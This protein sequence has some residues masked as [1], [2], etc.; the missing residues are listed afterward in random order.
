VARNTGAAIARGEYL[1]FLDDDDW[2]LPGALEQFW[3]LAQNNHAGWLYGGSRLIDV[4]NEQEVTLHLGQSGNCFAQAMAGEWIP[5]QASLIKTEAFFAVGGFNPFA[6]PGE[7]KDLCQRI[8]LHNNFVNTPDNV[9]V[10][11]REGERT[12]H[13]PLGVKHGRREREKTLNETGCFIRM[14]RSAH[15]GY[16]H[17]RMVRIYMASIIWNL[18]RKRIFSAINRSVFGLAGFI[19]AGPNLF[20]PGFW[21]AMTRS[22]ISSVTRFSSGHAEFEIAV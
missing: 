22:H 17:G 8:A 15:S 19:L 13:Y 16:W 18:Q 6:T 5:L 9:A 10:I 2:L 12:A 11:L 3:R 1:H 14:R 7:D 21:R 20:T 4:E